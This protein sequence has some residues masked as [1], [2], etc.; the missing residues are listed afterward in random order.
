MTKGGR[1]MGQL[2]DIKKLIPSGCYCYDAR[3]VCPYW[4]LL[5]DKPFRENG[6][7]AYLGK[8]DWDLNE[9]TGVLSNK[10]GDLT[11][12][13]AHDLKWSLLWDKVKECDVNEQ[14]E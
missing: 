9:E 4:G 11:K 1:R 12:E 8:S 6:Y 3:G 7:C 13:T 10:E 14:L 5:D 2:R